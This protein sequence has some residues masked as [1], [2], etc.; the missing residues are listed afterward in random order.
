MLGGVEPTIIDEIR[1]AVAHVNGVKQVLGD[2]SR[3][4]GHHLLADVVVDRTMADADNVAETVRHEM[5]DHIPAL[6]AENVRV[7][8]RTMR[9]PRQSTYI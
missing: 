3:W 1:Q 4:L 9:I 8:S 6:S 7:S 2:R 5:T